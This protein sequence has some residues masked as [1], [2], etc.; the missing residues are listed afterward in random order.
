M[1]LISL[2]ALLLVTATS[3]IHFELM[4]RAAAL[5]T[6]RELPK[7][8]EVLVLLIAAFVGHVIGVLIYA[9]AYSWLHQHPD[10][11]VIAGR[12]SGG[13]VDYIYF[14]LACYTTLGFGDIYATDDM[15]LIAG[16]EGLNGLVLIAWSASF[17]FLSVQ[18]SLGED[19]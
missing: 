4:T 1:I 7:R 18:R 16:L 2:I 17:T 19:E 9:L 3:G 6:E 8:V 11:G 15:R 5:K 14:S 10:F 12:L 13:S